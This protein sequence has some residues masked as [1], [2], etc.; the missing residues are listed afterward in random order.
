MKEKDK[1]YKGGRPELKPEE[2]ATKVVQVRFTPVEYDQL[3][4]RKSKVKSLNVSSFIRDVCLNKPL[5]LKPER[6]T[7]QDI[8]LSLMQETRSDVLRIGVNINQSAKRI[9]ST[10][11]YQILQQQV[12]KMA[13][14][15]ERFDI[16]LRAI[17]ARIVQ[18]EGGISG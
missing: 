17:M 13:S 18:G 14:E 5:R 7:Y 1:W 6:T 16:E 4:A 2:K 3:L 9:N 8:L 10:T 15:M 11:D 12:T